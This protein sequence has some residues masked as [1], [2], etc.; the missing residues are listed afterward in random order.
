MT[1]RCRASSSAEVRRGAAEGCPRRCACKPYLPARPFPLLL[2]LL[3]SPRPWSHAGTPSLIALP[4]LERLLDALDR[5]FGLAPGAEVSIEADPGTFDAAR[6]RSYMDMGI[7]RVSVGVQV[8]GAAAPPA[9][10]SPGVEGE[11]TLGGAAARCAGDVS[12]WR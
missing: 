6:L 7:T 8:R 12:A 2:L 9:S 10:E 3:L 11:G 4:L 1:H 5:R